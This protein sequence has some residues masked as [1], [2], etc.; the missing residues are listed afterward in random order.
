MQ[1]PKEYA[2]FADDE[3]WLLAS[4]VVAHV[5]VQREKAS[6]NLINVKYLNKYVRQGRLHPRKVA[7]RLNWYPWSEVRLLGE[8]LPTGPKVKPDSELSKRPASI[9]QRNWYRRNREKVAGNALI[10]K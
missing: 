1:S 4:Q 5:N 3:Y 2:A 7:V 10:D 8:T 6:E 9:H